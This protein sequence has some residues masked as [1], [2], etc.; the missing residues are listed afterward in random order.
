M[1]PL[2]GSIVFL[3]VIMMICMLEDV[4]VLMTR[5]IG[6]PFRTC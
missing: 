1:A 5:S 4:W 3:R 6:I 2:F